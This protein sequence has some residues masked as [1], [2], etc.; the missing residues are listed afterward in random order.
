MK[1]ICN[2]VESKCPT[3][4]PHRKPHKPIEDRYTDHRSDE[5]YWVGVCTTAESDCGWMQKFSICQEEA[6]P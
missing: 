3:Y 5:Y 6:K 2:G 1:V 4:C